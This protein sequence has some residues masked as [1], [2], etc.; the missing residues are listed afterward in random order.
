MQKFINNEHRPMLYKGECSE[1]GHT[2]PLYP[3][4][5]WA[6]HV[7]E[8][9]KITQYQILHKTPLEETQIE[10][11]TTSESYLVVLSHPEEASILASTGYFWRDLHRQGR[12]VR[13]TNVSCDKC[14]H[15]YSLKKLTVYENDFGCIISITVA[16]IIGLLTVLWLG[17]L[18]VGLFVSIALIAIS[19]FLL[20][21]WAI[22]RQENHF[23]DIAAKLEKKR[24]CP[25]C[26]V[27]QST[28]IISNEAVCCQN[29]KKKAMRFQTVGN[30]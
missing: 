23:P 19:T 24:C 17:K 12:Y 16:I 28:P 15:I 27:E 29:C 1:C 25:K 10:Y 18:L 5:F 20:F 14:G 2:T 9:V 8:P 6:V 22:S 21:R 7:D 11:A 13:C 30:S 4:G 3:E 26:A